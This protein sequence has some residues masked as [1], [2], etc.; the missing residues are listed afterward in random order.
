[1]GK[2]RSQEEFILCA[3]NAHGDQYDYSRVIYIG[4]RQKIEIVCRHHGSF[5][6]EPR[7]HL[8]GHGCMKCKWISQTKSLDVFV[9]QA[10]A[11]HGDKYD[12]SS[13]TYTNSDIKLKIVCFQHGD[14]FQMPGDHLKGQ[15]CPVCA[16]KKQTKSRELFVEEATALHGSKYDYSNVN[17]TNNHTKVDILCQRHGNFTQTPSDHLVGYGCPA[18]G[19]ESQTK[20]RSDTLQDFLQ[21]AISAHGSKYDY[22]GVV[23]VNSRT[24]VE[25]VCPTHG[26]FLQAPDMHY[27]GKGCPTCGLTISYMEVQWLDSLGI[28]LVNRQQHLRICGKRIRADAFDPNTNTIYEF[29]GDFW[30]GN[31][32]VY[33]SND[34][35]CVTKKSFGQ[36][37][38][39]TMK[40]EEIIMA[41]GYNL[42]SIWEADYMQVPQ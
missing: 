9:D 2:K 6:Q 3:M 13:T 34:I 29:Y 11:V 10:R 18:C 38:D 15:G 7:L 26:K 42:V 28:P 4:S 8:S 31:P 12:Y 35:N 24:K 36:L 5:Y 32:R 25:I 30:H 41:A 37:Y 39:E 1:M 17:Y 23:Y 21:K 14:F 16:I 19:I 22:S 40:K 33:N 27:Y 20:T